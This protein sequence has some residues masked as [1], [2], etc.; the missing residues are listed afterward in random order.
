MSGAADNQAHERIVAYGQ[1]FATRQSSG[2]HTRGVSADM[3]QARVAGQIER[4]GGGVSR[5]FTTAEPAA[6]AT[7]P[8]ELDCNHTHKT[9]IRS[10]IYHGVKAGPR[11]SSRANVEVHEHNGPQLIGCS[12]E[13]FESGLT[14]EL[15]HFHPLLEQSV[16]DKLLG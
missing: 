5:Q 10:L 3:R 4:F 13:Q 12:I 11:T 7:Q 15:V 6:R 14:V 2:S 8:T 16:S 9:R 1:H